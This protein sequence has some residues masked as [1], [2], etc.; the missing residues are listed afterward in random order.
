M[1][2]SESA[3]SLHLAYNELGRA[4]PFLSR[5]TSSLTNRSD[6]QDQIPIPDF[7]VVKLEKIS[8][9]LWLKRTRSGIRLRDLLKERMIGRKVLFF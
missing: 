7:P 4:L 9:S 3:T 5:V 6:D 2:A 8:I 1:N